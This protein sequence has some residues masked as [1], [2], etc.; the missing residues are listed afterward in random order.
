MA[1]T[2]RR[3]MRARPAEP[4][5]TSA[6][7]VLNLEGVDHGQAREQATRPQEEEGQS[8]QAS[9]RLSPLDNRLVNRLQDPLETLGA[10]VVA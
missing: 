6:R 5:L 9:Q 2:A 4:R 8:R 10:G 7:K 1:P 3:L